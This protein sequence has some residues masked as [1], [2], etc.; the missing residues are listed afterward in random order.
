MVQLNSLV[1]LLALGIS[2]VNAVVIPH[3]H[4]VHEKR[5]VLHARW[6]KRDRVESHK[7]LQMRIG[8]AQTNLDRGYEKLMDV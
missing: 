6:S 3:T 1:S 7:L 4:E 5:G 8:L 2:I